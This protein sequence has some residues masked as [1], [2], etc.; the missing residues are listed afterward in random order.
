MVIVNWKT[1]VHGTVCQFKNAKESLAKAC[2]SI[3][4]LLLIKLDKNAV[5]DEKVRRF[6]NTRTHTQ[7]K[8]TH[9]HGELRGYTHW[10]AG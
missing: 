8:H 2:R 4:S 3:A 9:V 5:Y 10:Y 7:T 1:Q 6:Q